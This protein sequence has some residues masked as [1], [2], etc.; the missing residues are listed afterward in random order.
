MPPRKKRKEKL[1]P[2]APGPDPHG[3]ET[4]IS[5]HIEWMLTRNFS[6]VTVRARMYELSYFV[7]WCADRGLT[8]PSE[9]TMKAISTDPC[10]P[11][12]TAS[13]G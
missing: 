1:A 4:L 9:V 13:D 6:E 12:R 2:P 10:W 3:M 8:R 5:A 11:S 7:R